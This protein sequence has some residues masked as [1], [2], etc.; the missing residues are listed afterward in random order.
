MSDA[1]LD[2][3][4]DALARHALAA[5]PEA[6]TR[7]DLAALAPPLGRLLSARLDA[8]LDRATP[9][10]AWTDADATAD[11]TAAWRSA[12]EPTLHVPA[13][14][15]QSVV[16]RAT[17]RALA[18]LVRPADT[19][20]A[21]AFEGEAGPL[22]VGVALARIGAF[23][24]YPYLVQIAE[25]YIERKDLSHIDR[26]GLERLLRRIDRRMVSAFSADDWMALLQ[27]LLDWVG[28]I[29]RPPGTVPAGLL[30]A[31]FEAKG[32]TA[33]HDAMEE[34]DTVDAQTIYGLVATALAPDDAASVPQ[35][36]AATPTSAEGDLQEQTVQPD[37]ASP[38]PPSEHVGDG[39]DTD[40]GEPSSSASDGGA[41]P[42]AEQSPATV[43]ST[44]PPLAPPGERSETDEPDASG[45]PD[46]TPA[47]E[48]P[49][50]P[51][52][53]HA[54]PVIG[55]RYATPE[56]DA[57][58][59]SD[60]IGSPRPLDPVE[61]VRDAVAEPEETAPPAAP[62]APDLDMDDVEQTDEGV[63]PPPSASAPDE[64]EPLWL[65]LARE[66][67]GKPE[68]AAADEPDE[69]EPLWKRF[70]QSDLAE[71]LP[72]L[73]AEGD[74]TAPPDEILPQ[75]PA[76]QQPLPTPPRAATPGL[77]LED[78]EAKVLGEG[79]QE[80]RDWYVANLF[81]GSPGEYHRTL[82][83]IDAAG[84]YTD[85]TAIISSEILRKRSVSPY[86]DCAVAF[87][88]A[89]QAQFEGR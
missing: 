85:A 51:A 46:E 78:L 87:I 37:A 32:A 35:A 16:E 21:V 89:V 61:S 54:P 57:V 15:R 24:P 10:S 81:G 80:R 41:S 18:H 13:D 84:S 5:L 66:Q 75:V 68:P 88:D 25:R 83:A 33:L 42:E 77:F 38:L 31:L 43:E 29:G 62:A 73:P 70:A 1:A 19:L 69:D 49:D 6:P 4:A 65:R 8:E 30:R 64:D 23:G 14:R 40:G 67:A 47:E 36:P 74:E 71:R 79:A 17:V 9:A 12:A 60:V 22:P 82:K 58:D 86:T 27:P 34:I 28:P 26:A 3:T 39:L 59:D 11:A 7:A 56:F 63:P 55:S 52:D 50:P 53:G 20:A 76:A 45:L 72:D 48:S 2:A 44:S